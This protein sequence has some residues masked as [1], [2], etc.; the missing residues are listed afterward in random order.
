MAKYRRIVLKL[1][2]EALTNTGGGSFD[3]S[4]VMATALM[5][6]DLRAM[7]VQAAV[8]I[9]GGNIWR[10]RFTEEMNPVNADQMG[11][12]ATVINALCVEDALLR[13]G[14][15]AKVF[16]AQEMTRFASLYTARA[17]DEYLSGGG[18]A[19][20]AG[21]SGHP[22]FTTDTASALRAAELRADAFFKGTTVKGV[23]DSDPR[24][25]PDAKLYRD[26]TYQ[27]ALEKK[28][29]VMDMTAFTICIQQGVP[30]IRV[31]AMDDLDNVLKVARG[32][33]IGTFVHP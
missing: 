22:F 27:E 30:M 13:T 29:N 26:L 20:L 31:F 23:Y 10:G 14:T 17:A 7:D 11:M 9:G 24:K 6:K 28:L 16:T 18:I 1:S 15:P 21:G 19:L 2:G 12:L 33:D 3:A 8:V 5:L 4:R 25:N 32:E